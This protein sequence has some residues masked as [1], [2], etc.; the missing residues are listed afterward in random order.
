MTYYDRPPSERVI[1]PFE[2]LHDAMERLLIVNFK[3][4]PD[5]DGI[6]LQVFDDEAKGSGSAALM[7]R[8]D[9]KLDWYLTPGLTLDREAA[10]VG[11]GLGEWVVDDFPCRLDIG[12]QG[13]DAEARFTLHDG[14]EV[15]LVLTEHRGSPGRHIDLLAPLG[16]GIERP[17]FLPCFVMFGIDL[18]RRGGTEVSVRIGGEERDL[19]GIPVPIPYS[20]RFSYLARY[21]DD[22][23]ITRVNPASDGPARLVDP[24]DTTGSG[25]AVFSRRDGHAE[26]TR[27][28]IRAAGHEAWLELDPPLPDLL[29]LADGAAGSGRFAIGTDELEMIAGEVSFDRAGDE[30]RLTLQP[31]EPWRPAGGPLVWLTLRMFPSFFRTWPTTYRWQAT[32]SLTPEPTIRSSWSRTDD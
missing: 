21:C 26:L 10:A 20:G 1:V 11:A 8:T 12:Q 7:Y 18:V 2:L 16:V 4:D 32:L 28:S 27:L 29:S 31:S 9:G 3:D 13:V 25:G 6:E 5:Y 22:P 17:V 15:E 19:E 14:R 24:A 30:V 23:F